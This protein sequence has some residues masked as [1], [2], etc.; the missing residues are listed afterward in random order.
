MPTCRQ[1]WRRHTSPT[2]SRTVSQ[3]P[4]QQGVT[5]TEVERQL[6]RLHNGR[7][8][9]QA[10]LP[11]Q[12]LRYA[13]E[14]AQSGRPHPPQLLGPILAQVFG[15]LFQYACLPACRN[16]G[17]VPPVYKRR[18]SQADTASYR[19]TAGTEP[20]KHLYASVKS[21]RLVTF[22]RTDFSGLP[23]RLVFAHIW[24]CITKFSLCST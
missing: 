24:R 1:A 17:L 4:P 23:V 12:L 21:Q 18:C 3:Q 15:W 16:L 2:L 22:R 14:T 11:A 10:G 7:A 9:G 6:D 13:R 19:P 20:S 8:Y 5:I